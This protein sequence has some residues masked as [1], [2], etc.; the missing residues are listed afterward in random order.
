MKS[1]IEYFVNRSFV[2]NLISAFIIFAGV[3]LGSMI[4]RDLIPPFE[5]KSVNV[6]VS[7]PGAS[8]TEV[9]KY[10]AYPIETA[11]QGLPHSKEITTRSTS[12]TLNIQVY[13]NASHDQMSESV[14]QIRS[15]IQA[16]N[17]QLPSQSRD[18]NVSQNKVDSVFHMG[19]ALENFDFHNPT[20]RQWVKRLAEKIRQVKGIID[21]SEEMNS[22]NLYIQI[23]PE[24][25]AP[26]EISVA[27]IRTK[28]QESLSYSP[29]GQVDFDEKTFSVEI[30]RPTEAIEAFKK[31]AIR[32]N[33]TGNVIYLEQLADI[34]L[35][36]D[37]V[38]ASHKFNGNPVIN[39][40]TR[41]D[42]TSDSILLKEK[43][44]KILDDTNE[45]LPEGVRASVFIDT[46]KLIE[47]QL[48]TLKNNGL[49]G[50]IL[51]LIILTLFFNWK[52]SLATS[53]GIPIAY[54][55]TL[56]ALYGFGISIDIISV[57]GMILVLGI[58]VD[59]A[60]IIAE[61]YIENLEEG[62]APKEA[63]IAAS[64]DLMI[65][66]TGTV[67]TTVFAFT[68]MVLLESEIANVFYAVPIVII[69]S[70][71]MSWLE[72][73]FILP[74]HM[75]H[76]IK[77]APQQSQFQFFEK[78]KSLYL[79][80]INLVL[81]FRY[82][83]VIFLVG[84]FVA[85]GWVAKNKIQQEFWFNISRERIAI[86]ITL[87]ENISLKY[88]EKVLQPIED[89]LVTLPK[90]KFQ[91]IQTDVGNMWTRGRQYEGYRY[92]KIMLH[93]HEDITNPSVIKKEFT[94]KLKDYFE[95]YQKKDSRIE[96][97]RIGSEMN[98]QDDQKKDMISI[99]VSG[100]E[101]VDYLEIK[102]AITA[103]I[104]QNKAKLEMVKE[105]NEFD[106]KWVFTPDTNKLARYQMNLGN[107]TSQL[108]SFFVPHE[109][110]QLRMNGES[111][112]IYTQVKRDK[113]I[114]HNELKN[115]SV[116]N[117]I[118]LSVPLSNLGT[119]SKKKQLGNIRHQDGKRMFT[120]DLAFE[121]TEEMNVIKAKEEGQKIANYLTEHYP[122]YNIELRD[123][124]RAEASSRAWALKVAFLCIVLVMFTLAL[125]LNSITLPFLVGLPIPFG[126]M[127]IVWALYLHDMKMGIMSLI[128]LIGTVGV[129]VND[130][131]IM[132]DQIMK[133]AQKAG[134]LLRDHII[135]GAASRLRAIILTTVTTLGGVFPMAY[136]IGGE[137]GYTQ[138]LAF[139]LGWGLFFSTFLTLFALPAFMEIRRDFSRL[140]Q[141]TKDR[142]RHRQLKSH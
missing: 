81:R 111:K 27:E 109:L 97:V 95:E 142:I 40:Y 102:E 44:Q 49:F 12:G 125:V 117:N 113:P 73:F 31:M 105:V 77:K 130:S 128:G 48:E 127:G 10:L 87:K 78:I 126:L 33:K 96:T 139:S 61:R 84:F 101:D 72:S 69:V 22:Q 24:K 76:F 7:L 129:S 36:I 90:D 18:I 25:L 121:P 108:R 99:D 74:N 8:A 79:K 34:E 132:V 60:I 23:H 122:T 135:N 103:Q 59:D 118:G 58:L 55:G 92:A 62:M 52:V 94:K 133:R 19:I 64:K 3:V 28:L 67:L 50:M 124:D 35:K 21:V 112:W 15:R 51:V 63:A 47:S 2:V 46:P 100:N 106:E 136:G 85:S 42:I 57:V 141:W 83:V 32:S 13:F 30:Q 89:Y 110:M 98:D 41:K 4:K 56:I 16:I 54:C 123:A 75:Q 11:L 29:I 104:T 116:L 82:L 140:F 14:E 115:L 37:E 88:T 26:Y 68:P 66:V 114:S 70:L 38:K 1:I 17:W 43:V 138:P 9:E 71:T 119:W 6:S 20:H 131:L 137:S 91:F 80:I 120:F 39:L 53:F 45:K 93:I 86:K 65:P 107:I 5:W 134:G